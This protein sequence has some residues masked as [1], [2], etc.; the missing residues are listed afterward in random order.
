MRLLAKAATPKQQD[1][2]G[3]KMGGRAFLFLHTAGFWE[4]FN[5]MQSCGVQLTE[6]PRQEPYGLV[7]VFL[8]LYGNNWDL[9]QANRER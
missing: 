3:N 5:H 1:H 4:N 7:V 9:I 6:Q 2:I 8:D